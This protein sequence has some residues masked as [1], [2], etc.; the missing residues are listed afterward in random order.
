MHDKEDFFSPEMVD[1]RLELSLLQRDTGMLEYDTTGTDPNLRLISDLRYLYGAEGTENVRSLQRVWE[2]LKEQPAKKEPL[3]TPVLPAKGRE[4]HL[5]LLKPA[6]EGAFA[7]IPR[8]KRVRG[9]GWTILAA[10]LF[11]V[12]MVGSLLTIVRLTREM[13]TNVSVRNT[14]TPNTAVTSQPTSIPNYP[15]APPGVS[16]GVSPSSSDTIYALAWSPDSKQLATSTEGKVWL[17]DIVHKMYRPLLDAQLAG[18]SVKALAWSPDGRYL[19][20]GTNPIQIV[21]AASGKSIDTVSADYPFLPVPGQTT[22]ITALAWSHS[23]GT[24]LAV[25][26]QHA[27]G[28]CYVFVWDLLKGTGIYTFDQQGSTN[29]ISSVSWSGDNRYV[30]SSDGQT[31]QAWDI[32]HNGFVIFK[33]HVDAATNVA[34]SPGPGLLAFVNKQMT[35]VWD[36]WQGSNKEGQLVSDYPAGNGV[37]SWSDK[38]Q[39]LATA[40][41]KKVVIFD[42]SSGV[43]IYTYTGN[44]HY[45]YSLAW[46]PDGSSIA[47]G[48]SDPSGSNVARVWSA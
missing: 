8:S 22:L 30:A 25:A 15:Y 5:H 4:R 45:V 33:Q 44:A 27:N 2:H 6:K 24:M 39:Y 37:L 3:P 19:A 38:G 7:F 41:G 26:T 12:L 20:V 34:W 1:E 42:A 10:L 40:N 48:E 13:Q 35:Q 9:R 32:M 29:G 36:V 18:G 16:L 14:A 28:A 11:L 21:D 47:T 31:V 46:S 23:S 17:W 43:S